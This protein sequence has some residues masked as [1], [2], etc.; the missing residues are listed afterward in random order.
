MNS[1]KKGDRVRFK[2]T[3]RA[4]GSWELW[5]QRAFSFDAVVT[6]ESIADNIG[7][8]FVESAIPFITNID[9]IEFAKGQMQLPFKGV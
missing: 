7:I 4:R 9:N 8:Y 2:N 1:F 5:F 3:K 6:I